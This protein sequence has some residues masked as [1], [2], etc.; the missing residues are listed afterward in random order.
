MTPLPPRGGPVR[1]VL[2]I[3]AERG[4][5]L[6][7]ATSWSAGRFSTVSIQRRASPCRSGDVRGV[8]PLGAPGGAPE[9]VG[10]GP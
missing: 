4:G 10:R 2:N 6:V 8:A 9:A 1:R 7:V 3:V 5:E